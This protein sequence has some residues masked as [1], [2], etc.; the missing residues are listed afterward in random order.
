MGRFSLV[1]GKRMGFLQSGKEK[2]RW[3]GQ[4][5]QVS[6]CVGGREGELQD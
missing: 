3:G 1:K 4:E 2:A 6:M 5:E